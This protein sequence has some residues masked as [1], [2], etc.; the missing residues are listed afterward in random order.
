MSNPVKDS[1][2]TI[3]HAGMDLAFLARVRKMSII[4]GAVAAIV[5]GTYYGLGFG[6]GFALGLAWSLVNLHFLGNLIKNV[7]TTEDKRTAHVVVAVVLKFPLL[8]ALG[9]LLI[10]RDWLSIGGLVAG[11]SW[12]FAVL[13][14]KAFGRVYL[15]MDESKQRMNTEA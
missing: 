15:K 8:Y 9:F 1:G 6:G 4:T 5:L 10:T 14:L 3:A 13:V 7:I 2:K 11:F 12:P